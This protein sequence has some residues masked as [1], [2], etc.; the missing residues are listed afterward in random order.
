MKMAVSKALAGELTIR[1]A[2]ERYGIPKSTLSDRVK[3]LKMQKE[4]T[5]EPK[6]GRY[7]P[8]FERKYEDIL[9]E[10]VRDLSNRLMPL[11]KKEFL[12][13]A[14]QLSESLNL[15]HRF[16]RENKTAGKDFYYSFMKRHQDL[17]LRTAESTSIMRC[18]G[19][20]KP[21][22]DRFFGSLSTL[23]DTYNFKPSHIYNCDE[24]GVT[25]VQKHSKVLSMKNNRQVGKLTSAERGKNITILFI[26]H[27]CSGVFRSSVFLY[28]HGRELTKGY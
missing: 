3:G 8:T 19:F 11:T 7:Q 16:N 20:N 12:K 25:T 2:A 4:V 23:L 22:V 5:F 14:F 21:Q 9:V 28:I 26:L 18:V 24:T 6:L 1:S 17:S 10:H 13:L 15:P 27:E